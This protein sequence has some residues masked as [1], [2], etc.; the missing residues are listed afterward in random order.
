AFYTVLPSAGTCPAGTHPVYRA[1]NKRHLEQDSNHRLTPSY[2][3]YQRA[4]RFLGYADEGIAFCS[5]A[6][7]LAGGDLQV[8]YTYPG[9]AVTSGTPLTVEFLFSNNGAGAADGGA[10]YA[11]LPQE[12]AAW[13]ITCVARRGATCPSAAE[14]SADALRTGVV[15]SAWPA[16]GGLTLTATG[17]APPVPAGG[18]ATLAFPATVAHASGR[19]DPAPVNDTPAIA[20]AVVKTA[21]VCNVV[22]NPANFALGAGAQAPQASVIA[23]NGCAWTAQ[24]SVPWV[25]VAP[26]GGSGDGRVTL[27]VAANPGVAERSGTVTIAGKSIRITQAGISC[28]YAIAPAALGVGAA[29]QSAALALSAPAGCAWNAQS[30]SGWAAVA[31]VSGSGPG[32][33]TV[34]VAANPAAAERTASVTIAT[35]VVPVVQAAVVQPPPPPA[36][37]PDPCVELRLQRDGDQVAP[38]GLTGPLGIGVVVD[39]GCSWEAASSVPWVTLTAGGAGSGSGFVNYLALPNGEPDARSGAIVIQ[40]KGAVA[41]TFTV[42]QLGAPANTTGGSDGGGDGGGGGGGDGGGGSGGDS[43]GDSG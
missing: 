43:G 4:V 33:I 10:L 20:L 17:T 16:G 36:P 2:N 23:G 25:V 13:T 12:V 24:S 7:P 14:L 29:A 30:S 39:I 26:A 8:T 5:P 28:T 38:E 40:A 41:R 35:L 1:Y 31:P 3:D 32:T 19:P 42:N 21:N 37:A 11:V 34:T 15:V 9:A 22:A 6:N 18:D 27:D